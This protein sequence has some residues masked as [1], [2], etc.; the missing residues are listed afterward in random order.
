MPN[1]FETVG[2]GIGEVVYTGEGI[3]ARILS[4][5]VNIQGPHI[6]SITLSGENM[7]SKVTG[8][9]KLNTFFRR[10]KSAQAG[11]V[12]AVEVGFYSTAK[13]PDGTPVTNVAAWNEFGTSRIPERPF[14]RQ[15]I[16]GAKAEIT[17]ILVEN[18]DPRTMSVDRRTA[19]LVGQA[20]QGRIQRSITTLRRPANAPSTIKAKGSS[21][22]LIDTMVSCGKR[23]RTKS[24]A[25][26]AGRLDIAVIAVAA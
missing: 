8:G 25:R 22:P 2:K 13:Y 5:R 12:R 18:V 23:L 19:G 3:S 7:A 24:R 1:R 20:M 14:F 10:A 15:A 9:R 16:Q 4:D 26:L 11:S 6:G 17:P 21:N